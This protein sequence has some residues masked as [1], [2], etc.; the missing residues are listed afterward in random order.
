MIAFGMLFWFLF[1]EFYFGNPFPNAFRNKFTAWIPVQ[2]TDNLSWR[3]TKFLL[4][5]ALQQNLTGNPSQFFGVKMKVGD[6][7]SVLFQDNAVIKAGNLHIVA[8]GITGAIK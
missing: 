1:S 2:S 5:P 7:R 8:E 6:G 3:N 4:L